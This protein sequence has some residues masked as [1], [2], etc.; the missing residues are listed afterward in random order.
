MGRIV[1]GPIAGFMVHSVGWSNFFLFTIPLGLPGLYMLSRF[2]K[3][4]EREPKFE[5]RRQEPLPPRSAAQLATH[6]LTC[7]TLTLAGGALLLT[8]LAALE[9]VRDGEFAD[10][11]F[12][13]ALLSVA[14][15]TDMFGWIQLAGLITF[16][17]AIG[18][19]AAAVQAARHGAGTAA[20]P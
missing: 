10:F 11:G 5:V 8:G 9:A 17:V 2:V 14:T 6:G 19:F 12:G 3:P 15:P 4:R 13:S 16:G 1:S 18:L 20:S 7:G